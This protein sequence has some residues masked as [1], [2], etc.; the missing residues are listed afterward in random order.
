MKNF[1]EIFDTAPSAEEFDQLFE[2]AATAP[3]KKG[4]MQRVGGAISS[5]GELAQDPL[6]SGAEGLHDFSLGAAQGLTLGFA[7]ELA[8]GAGVLLDP[9]IS[10]LSGETALDEQ[11]RQEGATIPQSGTTYKQE[12]K[13]SRREFDRAAKESEYLY[14]AGYLGGS[15]PSGQALGGAL[16]L[17]TKGT[18]LGQ[19]AQASKAGRVGKMAVEGALGAGI[20]A[21][22]SSEGSVT[23]TP[24]QQE[25]LASDLATGVGIGA[26]AGGGIGALGQVAAPAAKKMLEPVAE[27]TK[28][29]YENTPYLRQLAG[30]FKK[31]GMDYGV[32]PRSEKAIQTGVM[33]VEGGTP[34]S[35]LNLKRTGEVV[36]VLEKTKETL[37]KNV[38]KSLSSDLKLDMDDAVRNFSDNFNRVAA[39]L[40]SINKDEKVKD[41]LQ[42]LS[43]NKYNSLN[44]KEVKSLTDQ[45]SNIINRTE[46][47]KYSSMELE[48]LSKLLNTFRKDLDTNLKNALPEYAKAANDYTKFMQAAYEQPIMGKYSPELSDLFYSNL[49]DPELKLT[50]A[51]EKLIEETGKLSATDTQTSFSNLQR[52]LQKLESEGVPLNFKSKDFL[53]KLKDYADDA[54]IR[55]AV[56]HT[57]ESQAG[58]TKAM[59]LLT[60]LGETGKAWSY[61]GAQKAGK[62]VGRPVQ[63]LSS[64]VQSLSSKLYNAP[65]DQLDTLAN[66]LTQIPELE[67]LG[68]SLKEGIESNDSFKRNAALFSI[69][70]NPSAK[71]LIDSDE[72]VGD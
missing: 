66:R 19:L 33:G 31:Y 12:L 38:E 28:D 27:F 57:Q 18:R 22:G 21:I 8:A 62:Y 52:A 2:V 67:M 6:I 44:P 45:L 16:S 49:K 47:S 42:L 50:K 3:G 58:P 1:D 43:K 72:E 55:D 54:A 29:I 69:M 37:G 13:R 39:E 35:Q 17:A 32:S 60:G 7:D 41:I 4:L 64:K 63:S 24:E 70:Q 30:S 53:K 25:Q 51:Y 5:G 10:R 34:F 48:E 68:R 26:V 71:L 56:V 61:L 11:L 59:G 40:P 20:E 15:L 46:S 36:D 14:G 23:G 65:I 9:L